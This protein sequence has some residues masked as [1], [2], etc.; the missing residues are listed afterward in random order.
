[1]S[2]LTACHCMPSRCLEE[3]RGQDR[4]FPRSTGSTPNQ[5]VASNNPCGN[6]RVMDVRYPL[7]GGVVLR[8]KHKESA[9]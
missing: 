1:M 2:A 4:K 5:Q 3:G 8:F 6:R 7:S 9:Q